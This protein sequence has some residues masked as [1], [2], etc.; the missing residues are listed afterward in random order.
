MDLG[1]YKMLNNNIPN[2]T[3][4]FFTLLCKFLPAG[5]PLHPEFTVPAMGT[6]MCKTQKCE[7]LWFSAFPPT[8]FLCK[9]SKLYESGFALFQGHSEVFH[10]TF[11]MF[12]EFLCL[13]LILEAPHKIV[14][15]M[16]K[17]V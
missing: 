9:P 13:F 7:G 3:V 8:S 14:G 2:Q 15:A 5:F 4:Y 1:E 17:S 6:V 11:Q 10:P 12:I 16:P